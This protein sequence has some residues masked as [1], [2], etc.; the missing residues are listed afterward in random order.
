M[1]IDIE[2]LNGWIGTDEGRAW[3]DALKKP[4]LDKRDELLTGLRA[5][6][7]SAAQAA[8]RAADAEKTLTDER[9][10]MAS[11]L[12]ERDF[13]RIM[14]DG[15]VMEPC[16]PAAI[17]ELKETYGIQVKA[18]GPSREAFGKIKA[19]DGTERE[20]GLNEIFDDWQKTDSAKKITFA[21]RSSGGGAPGGGGGYYRPSAPNLGAM[22]GRD[23]ARMSDAD[24]KAAR[25]QA[26]SGH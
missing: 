3:A 10:A 18:D 12:I 24:F 4:L 8:Q 6:N 1:A 15:R 7:G 20:A 26:L 9:A 11:I 23:L 21:L 22:N 17:A 16:I 5:S 14:K 25:D 19:E 2:E 13:G